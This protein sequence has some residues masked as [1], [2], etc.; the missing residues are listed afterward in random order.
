M[1]IRVNITTVKGAAQH[2]Y[3]TNTEIRDDLEEVNRAIR[4]LKN[5][6][7]GDAVGACVC[8]YERIKGTYADARYNVLNGMFSFLKEQVGE[9]YENTEQTISTAAA[10]FK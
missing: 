10:A 6:W 8:E 3:R 2:I 4:W 7:E 5:N 9:Q 1:A